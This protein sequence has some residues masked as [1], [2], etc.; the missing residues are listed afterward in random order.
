MQPAF[1]AGCIF[2]SSE[3]WYNIPDGA[4]PNGRVSALGAEGSGFKSRCPD[5]FMKQSALLPS[6]TFVHRP[7]PGYQIKGAGP[8]R[9][10]LSPVFETADFS[11]LVLSVDYTTATRGWLLSEVQICQDGA[12]SEFFKLGFYS[13]KLNHSFDPQETDRAVL[14]VDELCAKMPAQAYRFRLTLQGEMEVSDVIV[15][16]EPAPKKASQ[17]DDLPL[18]MRQINIAPLSQMQLAVSPEQQ[19]RLCSPTSLCMALRA[20][21]VAAAPLETAAAVYDMQADIYGNWTF[22][23]AYA[24]RRGLFA[25]VTRFHLL[26]ELAD[27][28]NEHSLVLATIAYKKG[29][30]SGAA[31]EETPGHLVL[32]CGWKEGKIYVADPAAPTKETV[33]RC[34]DAKEFARA[35]LINKRGAAYLVRKK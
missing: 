33:M 17:A 28:V 16:V 26:A 35:W 20:L 2:F 4:W 13:P 21:G 9:T 8:E 24:A 25:C 30:L 22:N 34:Y 5:F 11:S 12:W 7:G 27:F 15:C 23:T 14:C 1:L 18:Q 31:V 19:K 32:I 3:N 29:E 6:F 10:V